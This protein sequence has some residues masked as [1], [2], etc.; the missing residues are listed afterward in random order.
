MALNAQAVLIPNN[1]A[2]I[3]RRPVWGAGGIIAQSV[4]GLVNV[5]GLKDAVL[6]AKEG[7]K[8][9]KVRLFSYG[10]WNG[11]FIPTSPMYFRFQN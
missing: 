2:I 6:F 1:G 7:A 11:G 5:P 4:S 3:R 8:A 10:L 9:L